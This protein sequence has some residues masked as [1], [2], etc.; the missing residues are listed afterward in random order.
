MSL[1]K[2]IINVPTHRNKYLQ[3]DDSG[4][5]GFALR[6]RSTDKGVY[7]TM[8]TIKTLVAAGCDLAPIR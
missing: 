5:W 2:S 6:E 3:V 4:G 7:R 8:E 1:H